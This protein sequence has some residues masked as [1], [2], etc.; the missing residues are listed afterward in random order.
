MLETSASLERNNKAGDIKEIT[1]T[2]EEAD[3][4]RIQEEA[5]HAFALKILKKQLTLNEITEQTFIKSAEDEI[6]KGDFAK[7]IKAT[8]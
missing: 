2:L 3:I 8:Q 5:N 4:A 6:G 7:T 1:L